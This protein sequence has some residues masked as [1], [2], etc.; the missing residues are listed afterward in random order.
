MPARISRRECLRHG[1]GTS[2]M[3]ALGSSVPGF[4]AQSAVAS[5]NDKST[6][7][8][9]VVV[10]LTGGNDGL[11]TVIPYTDDVYYRSRPKLAIPKNKVLKLNEDLGLHPSLKPFNEMLDDQ[12]LS[13]IQSVG[14]PNPV[15]SHFR[16]HSIWASG[17]LQATSLTQG[18]LSRYVDAATPVKSLDAP[19]I[20]IGGSS[21]AQPLSGGKFHAPSF[22]NM[23]Q[24]HRRI[25]VPTHANP[26]EQ[27]AKL[28]QVLGEQ[29]G[30]PTS[31]RNYIQETT[32]LSFASSKRLHGLLD[33]KNDNAGSRYPNTEFARRLSLVAQ[34]LKAELETHV[35][36]VRLGGFDTHSDQSI[37][38][39][40]LL[41]T[42]SGGLRAFFRDLQA[43]GESDRVVALV[44]SEFGRRLK[45]NFQG[46]TDHGTAGP[47]F[48]AGPA[49]KT[50]LHGGP[51]NLVDLDDSGD[52]KF[53]VD[54]RS[55]YS[56]LLTKWLGWND[57]N[58]GATNQKHE[59][60]YLDTAAS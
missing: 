7:R 54:F 26:D 13:I 59:S 12:M 48:L 34:L 44:F 22:D 39:S 9:L 18:W 21:V 14:Y 38:H 31:L 41:Q 32:V 3:L 19:A 35:Y 37:D 20:Q 42:L 47:V 49:A 11:N 55:V 10:E 51:P 2:A 52:P 56:H 17:E 57:H 43:S 30:D 29:V 24:L 40:V 28:D 36:Y 53:E 5:Q 16:S 6:E 27:R 1:V 25:G 45:E 8:I 60:E 50:G 33:A 15:R 46:G 58:L 4:L 23:E